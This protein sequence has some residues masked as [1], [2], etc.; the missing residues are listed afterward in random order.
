MADRRGRGAH[1]SR[2]RRLRPRGPAAQAK[3]GGGKSRLPLLNAK[4]KKGKMRTG[5]KKR[6][7]QKTDHGPTPE[8]SWTARGVMV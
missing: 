8:W 7:G 5:G 2:G 6:I 4:K 1:G 3:G